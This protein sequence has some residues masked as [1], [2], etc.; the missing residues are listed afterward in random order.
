[1]L[2]VIVATYPF[3]VT[4]KLTNNQKTTRVLEWNYFDIGA[5]LDEALKSK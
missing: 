2:R 5:S 4:H 3:P 1:M